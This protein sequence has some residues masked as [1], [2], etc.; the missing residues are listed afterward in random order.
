VASYPNTDPGSYDFLNVVNEY[1]NKDFIKFNKTLPRLQFINLLRNAKAL[2][3]NSSMGILEA[4]FYK[5]PVVNIGRRQQGRLTAGNVE[6]V[7]Y[8]EQDIVSSLE[9]ACFDLEYRNKIKSIESPYGNG[10]TPEI[11]Y[12]FLKDIDPKDKKFLIKTKLC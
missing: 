3:G 7:D 9:K 6:F 1:E 4:P 8:K 5:L 11:I 12:N 10:N 2:A